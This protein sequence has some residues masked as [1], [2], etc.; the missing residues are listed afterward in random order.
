MSHAPEFSEF[1]AG[2]VGKCK[3]RVLRALRPEY[4]MLNLDVK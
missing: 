3:S 1:D 4:G 2:L